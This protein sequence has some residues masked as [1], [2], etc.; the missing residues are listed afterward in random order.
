MR[1]HGR[2]VA[3]VLVGIIVAGAVL[4]W[5]RTRTPRKPPSNPESRVPDPEPRIPDPGS[6]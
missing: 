2:T 4:L 3:L 1:T 6:L 5:L